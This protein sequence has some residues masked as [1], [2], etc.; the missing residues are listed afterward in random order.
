[1]PC[2]DDSASR[3]EPGPGQALDPQQERQAP[4]TADPLSAAQDAEGSAAEDALDPT[5]D[6]PEGL[7]EAWWQRLLQV[8]QRCQTAQT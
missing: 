6:R 5:R 1:M 4:A 7:D 3:R 8:S 2:R